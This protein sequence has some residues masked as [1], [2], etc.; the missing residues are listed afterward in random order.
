M[1]F[2]CVV[3]VASI[4]AFQPSPYVSAYSATKAYVMLF[5]EGL[6]F[7]LKGTNVSVTTLY[8]GA[9]RTEFFE[10]S[11][12]KVNSIIESTMQSPTQVAEIALNA[13]FNRQR[14]I[15]P[16]FMN[17]ITAFIT[18]LSPR[19]LTTWAAAKLMH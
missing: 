14:S 1:V 15:V 19:K 17:K 13:M 11:D 3:W 18:Q 6:D 9:T 7:E 8:P 4:G 10:V 12:T 5:S 2:V 16:G